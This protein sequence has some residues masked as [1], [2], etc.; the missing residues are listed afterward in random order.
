[1]K[2]WSERQV[3]KWSRELAGKR[4]VSVKRIREVKEG[5]RSYLRRLQIWRR[6]DGRLQRPTLARV[7]WL[8]E[9]SVC[10]RSQP[11]AATRGI[12]SDS[13]PRSKS[14]FERRN[15]AGGNASVS[16]IQQSAGRARHNR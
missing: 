11:L 2:L 14:L 5:R 3:C 1:M 15:Q 10:G 6:A 13:H 12:H 7:V 16:G 8:V 4:R 9:N